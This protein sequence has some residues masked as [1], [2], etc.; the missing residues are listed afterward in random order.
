M[1]F[2]DFAS[3]LLRK[4]VTAAVHCSSQKAKGISEEMSLS[5]EREKD[6]PVLAVGLAQP[7]QVNED[8]IRRHYVYELYNYGM[9]HLGEEVKCAFGSW[10][11]L[12]IMRS[13]TNLTCLHLTFL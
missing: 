1:F 3:K 6:W 8:V 12:R 10:R 4:I 2:D 11:L 5:A 7:L 13:S 9:D